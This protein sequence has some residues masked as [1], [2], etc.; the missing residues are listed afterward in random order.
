MT[1]S[2]EGIYGDAVSAWFEAHIPGARGPFTFSLIAGGHSNLTSAVD[3]AGGQRFVL[4]RPPLGHV[5]QSA[6]ETRRDDSRGR[7]V[8]SVGASGGLTD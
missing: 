4:R 7:D 2:I 1:Q 5:L 6:H 8:P 3:D